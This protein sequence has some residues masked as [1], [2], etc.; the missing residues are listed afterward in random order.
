MRRCRWTASTGF[1]IGARTRGFAGFAEHYYEAI[2]SKR[3]KTWANEW[4][5]VAIVRGG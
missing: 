1:E 4:C 3:G 5:V 2:E